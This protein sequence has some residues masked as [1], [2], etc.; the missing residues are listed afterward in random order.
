MAYRSA[1]NSSN[2]RQAMFFV[3]MAAT[4]LRVYSSSDPFLHEWDERYHALVAKNCMSAPLQ[5]A[6]YE[7]PVLPYNYQNWVANHIWLHKPPLPL[8]IIAASM[9][10]GGVNL[11]ALRTPTILF[12]ILSIWLTFSIGKK[13]FGKKVALLASFFH[14]IHG[15]HI[16]MT[17]GR[18]TTDHYD[19]LFAFFIQ[20]SIYLGILYD[21]EKRVYLGIGSMSALG[22]ALLTK[23]LPALIVLPVLLFFFQKNKHSFSFKFLW[24]SLPYLFIP[25]LMAFS[26]HYYIHTYFPKEAAWESAY[27]WKHFTEGV[28]G[29]GHPYWHYIKVIRLIFGEATLVSLPWFLFYTIKRKTDYTIWGLSVWFF[30]P[31]VVFSLAATKMQGYILFTAPAVFIINALFIRYL[32]MNL[33]RFKFSWSIYIL[34]GLLFLLPIRYSLERLKLFNSKELPPRWQKEILI[35]KAFF[36]SQIDEKA[37]IFNTERYIEWMFH[38]NAIAYHFEPTESQLITLS[39]EGYHFFIEKPYSLSPDLIRKYKIQELQK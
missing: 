27:N 2:T 25:L 28:E 1:Q 9:S 15:L 16:E 23:W 11:W 5:P 18:V 8:W 30:V 24:N 21:E 39:E 13:L 36:K 35:N 19:V 33:K 34:I 17:G 3:L 7:N 29:H 22:A 38:T 14:A 12:S 37:I 26:W 20:A 32:L 4:I 6:L 31:I 10:L